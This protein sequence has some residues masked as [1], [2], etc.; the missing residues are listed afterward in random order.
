[1]SNRRNVVRIRPLEL[2]EHAEWMY[3]DD[4]N[5]LFKE[6]VQTK[7][8]WIVQA[9]VIGKEKLADMAEHPGW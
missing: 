8:Q 7:E 6:L 9:V 4:P 2:G 3:C 1:M 5:D